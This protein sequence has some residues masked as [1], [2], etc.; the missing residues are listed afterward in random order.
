MAPKRTNVFSILSY[1]VIFFA[2]FYVLKARD[3]TPDGISNTL[4]YIDFYDEIKESFIYSSMH[5]FQQD[6]CFKKIVSYNHQNIS[7]FTT[8]LLLCGDM[9]TCPGP[10]TL[11][12]LCKCRRLKF[13]HQNIRGPMFNFTL[14]QALVYRKGSK[15]DVLG[16]SETHLVDGDESD[17]AGLFKID[18]DGYTL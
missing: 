16:L 3:L 6:H 15:I 4:N 11:P 14:L 18:G 2:C 13:V 9:E 12:E 10:V 8:L 5:V 7:L 17:Y 1:F